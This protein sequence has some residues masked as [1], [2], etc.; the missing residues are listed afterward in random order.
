[1]ARGGTARPVFERVQIDGSAAQQQLISLQPA[2][3]G[4]LV[5][6]AAA[7]GGPG[8]PPAAAAAAPGKRSKN[9]VTVV[10]A[11]NAGEAVLLR[12]AAEGKK[13]SKPEAD[14]ASAAAAAAAELAAGQQ[15][16][17][18]GEEGE[19]EEEAFE[20][21]L[22]QR[23]AA[24]ER[25]AAGGGVDGATRQGGGEG[26]GEPA[27]ATLP[28][29]P[30]KADSLAV[31]LTQAL[32]SGDRALLERC[33][34]VGDARVVGNTVRRLLPADAAAFLR[35]AV[36][37][38]Q[39]KPARGQQLSAWI[40]AVLVHH[41]AYLMASPGVQAVLTSLYQTIEARLAMQR[42]LLSLSGRLDLLMVQARARTAAGAGC[43]EE[44]E[45]GGPQAVFQEASSDGEVEVEDPFAAGA[46]SE[47][48][49]GLDLPLG[50]DEDEDMGSGEEGASG[51]EGS[52]EE[53]GA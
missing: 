17:G 43:E 34:G 4:A 3:V 23:V 11:D 22:G 38:L 49:L 50:S 8:A 19:E 9:D 36:E 6:S 10:G 33:L 46:D 28:A 29:G 53:D 2:A 40:R 27:A 14:G 47:D 24:L 48:E 45:E 16:G 35:A 51:E 39:S 15:E 20:E 44:G 52:S 7:D 13:R 5:G 31:L 32:R 1:V 42:T 18:E 25:S 37:R 21:T 41:T 30:I 12:A 26:E